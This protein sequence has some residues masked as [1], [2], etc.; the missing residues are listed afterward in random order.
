MKYQTRLS[1]MKHFDDGPMHT[2]HGV[3]LS[4]LL[5]EMSFSSG[6]FFLLSGRRASE[7]EAKIFDKMLLSIIDHGMGTP[8]SMA[9][10]FVASGRTGM[11]SAV[12]AGILAVG[13]VHGG[14]ME[15][16]MEQY[17][18]WHDLSEDNRKQKINDA[19]LNKKTIY[20]FGHKVYKQGDPRVRELLALV[21]SLGYESKYLHIK[22]LVEG[23]FSEVKG[24]VIPMNI[25]GVI[26]LLLLDFGFDSKV[27]SGIFLIAR[28]AG[29][30]AQAHEEI[31]HEKPFRRV[32]EEIIEDLN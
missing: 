8:S 12:A 9:T 2:I 21:A 3:K 20:G 31:K 32:S 23:S 4:D 15:K 27:S 17:A 10:R 26:A 18:L 14:A 13:N 19:I 24:K 25:D 7:V 5:S 29:L 30:V 6:I 22:G 11:S 28:S 16:A 1:K